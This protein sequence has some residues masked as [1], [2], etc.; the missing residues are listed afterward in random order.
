MTG[1]ALKP[2]LDH[3]HVRS[4]LKSMIRIRRFEDT[5]AELYTQKKIRG[6]LHLYD[7]E[8]AVAAGVI[9]VLTEAD[10]IVA[11]NREHGHALMHGLPMTEVMAEMFGKAEGSAG[12]RGGSMHLF[13]AKANFY[14]GNAI[15]G[16]G[17][18]LAVASPSP[19]R[20]RAVTPSPPASS[21]R[22]QSKREIPHYY[23]SQSVDLTRA[24][25]VLASAN[26][27]RAPENR[28][29]LGVLFLSAVIRAA[30][31]YPEFNGHFIDG[32][33]RPAPKVH[34]AMAVALRAG[35]LVAPA[36][37]GSAT[38]IAARCSCAPSTGI[39]RRSQHHDEG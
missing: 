13:S 1:T 21:A 4:L 30:Q 7:G 33:F 14:G 22:A 28:L 10:R 19:T 16:G 15:V 31:D 27:G 38:A 9:P 6:F 39:C 18:P 26:A 3:A 35:G 12:G 17:M 8:E 32:A 11:T 37:I 23:L 2:R 25:D 29:L 20:C 34:A 24:S 5:C 36:I